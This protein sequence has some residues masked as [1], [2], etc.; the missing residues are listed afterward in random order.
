MRPQPL[1][2]VTDV[3]ASSR[4]YQRLLGCQNTHGGTEYERLVAKGVLILQLH[5]F[6]VEHHHG[7]IG[8]PTD[9]P[10]GNG[11]LLWFEI[12]DFDAA[13][14]RVAELNAEIVCLRHR[15]PPHGNGGPN[16]WECWLRDPDDY[17]VVLASP[18]GSADGPG[19]P[20]PLTKKNRR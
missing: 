2:A 1:I 13:M 6:K 9:K 16:P 3:E 4:W 19:N 20:P 7:A 8:N 11:V 17:L 5:R 10:Y 18:D 12:D 15:N 14:T